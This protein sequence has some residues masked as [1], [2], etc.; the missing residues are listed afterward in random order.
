MG[1]YL[2]VG[3][4]LA[5]MSMTEMLIR[6][7]Q[8][9]TVFD[10]SSQKAS[11][12]AG[13]LYNPVVLKRF[14][15]AWE[16][17]KLM[18]VALPFYRELEAKLKVVFDEKLDVLRRFANA[19]EQNLWFE[20]ADQAGLSEYL[21]T[22]LRSNTNQAVL[23]PHGFGAVRDTGR[24]H[25]SLMLGAYRDYLEAIGSLKREAFAY[26]DL[27]TPENELSYKGLKA[28]GVI[29]AEGFGLLEN[30]YFNYLPLKG[31]KGELL[32]IHA[33]DLRESQVIKAGIFLIPLGDDRY[34]AGATYEHKDNSPNPTPEAREKLLKGLRKVLQ[35]DF[36]VTGQ[37]AGIRP[38]VPD[39]RPMVGTHPEYTRLFVI[40]GMGSRG[41]LIGPYAALCLTRNIL[42]GEP[43]PQAMD[44]NRFSGRFHELQR[45][46]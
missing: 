4:G 8:R 38:T 22:E 7:G 10:D 20:A 1:H 33:P 37:R 34:L 15:L 41:V 14:N 2:V 42:Y 32:E 31:T 26:P 27:I 11:M 39:R 35:C 24:I 40:N 25:T 21:S 6:E 23:A 36:E 43:L 12:V 29:F 46:A 45:K 18:E 13:G 5:G 44:C 3:S 28:D 19:G 16:G 30:P 17:K 9:V